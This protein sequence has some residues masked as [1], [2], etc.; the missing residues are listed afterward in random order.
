MIAIVIP[1]YKLSF[2]EKTMQ[3][4]ANQT[5][6]NFKVYIGD[7]CSSEN[8]TEL[9]QSFQNK[10]DFKYKKF[11]TN[12]G[13]VSLVKQWERC[14]EMIGNEDWVMVLGDD[15]FLSEN[16]IDAFYNNIAKI[17]ANQIK[18]VRYSSQIVNEYSE[19]TSKIFT[20][21]E[22][23]ST[24]NFFYRRSNRS[25]RSSL[26]EYLFKNDALKKNFFYDFPL[27]WHSDDLAIL[28]CSNFGN[29]FTINNATIFVRISALSISGSENLEEKKLESTKLYFERLINLY[30]N[31]FSK[32]NLQIILLR[33]EYFFF[34]KKTIKNYFKISKLYIQHIGFF[35]F[36]KFN[37]RICLKI[38]L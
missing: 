5:N 24:N 22:I 10:I 11:D 25:T 3:S 15:D 23:E 18:V 19:L 36:L 38:K 34:M 1:Y 21:Q 20:H 14:F 16:V 4:L 37:R 26:S 32:V 6:K 35:G 30:S 2:F 28:E 27:A 13:S 31:K 29:I 9:L 8:P 7:D 33:L 12:L 17:N